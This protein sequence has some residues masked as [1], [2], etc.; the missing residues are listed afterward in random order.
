MALT[1]NLADTVPTRDE[2][3]LEGT[4]LFVDDELNI[5]SALRRLFRGPRYRILCANSGREGLAIL[6]TEAVDLIISD[7]RMPEM[8][9][10]T[11][12]KAVH[13]RWPDIVRIM[14]TGYA[15]LSTTISAINEAKIYRYISKP[16]EDNELH[17]AVDQA[18]RGRFL[19]RERERLERLTRTQNE[20]LTQ[21]NASLERMVQSRTAELQQTADMLDVA[22]S[23]L[24]SS[25]E[26][27]VR[28]FSSLI[29]LRDGSSAKSA[30][31]IVELCRRLCQELGVPSVEARDI[32]MAA[33]LYNIGKLSWSDELLARPWE[34]LSKAEWAEVYKYP[35]LSEST[36]MALE[37]LKDC[38]R[39][40]RHHQER[41][42]GKGFPDHL[43]GPQIPLGARVLKLAVDFD[44]LLSGQLFTRNLSMPEV[45]EFIGRN[46]GAAY[47]PAVVECYL[48]LFKQTGN[49]DAPIETTAEKCVA[50]SALKPGME[51]SRDLYTPSGILLLNRGKVLTAG[52]IE[53]IV[54]FEKSDKAAYTVHIKLTS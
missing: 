29:S 18:L 37:P 25:Y 26:T 24:K 31:R 9:G 15:D 17:M 45:H 12:L 54:A 33:S 38:A 50:T 51:L 7:A 2:V 35:I 42:D 39:I 46:A 13:A 47:D 36:L 49:L 48:H 52:Y 3:A 44:G 16:W 28:V 10:A 14:L 20:E 27:T 40:I 1:E 21:L 41:F 19:E 43:L 6:E 5:L 11:F 30:Q 34:S 23:E 8:D 53:R 22:Y 4:L 32:T